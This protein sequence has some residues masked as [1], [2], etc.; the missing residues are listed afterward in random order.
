[1]GYYVTAAELRAKAAAL[2]TM[3]G[4]FRAR[5]V[6][7]GDDIAAADTCVATVSEHWV[8]P[9]A[10]SDLACVSAY[11][12]E[13]RG[14]PYALGAV[15]AKLQAFADRAEE[16]GGFLAGC[17]STLAAEQAAAPPGEPL[18]PEAWS[19]QRR[20][21]SL[22]GD[23]NLACITHAAAITV[24]SELLEQAHSAYVTGF[25]A[26]VLAGSAYAVALVN[27]AA[28]AGVDLEALGYSVDEVRA[29]L[30]A[31][32]GDAPA[33]ELVVVVMSALTA[34]EAAAYWNTL[35]DEERLAVVQKRPDLAAKALDGGGT[36]TEIELG[37]L[38]E[39][40]AYP[41]FS[42]AFAVAFE[43]SVGLR[44]VSIEVGGGYTV[45]AMKMSDGTVQVAVVKD[46][47]AG[48]G[49]EAQ[50]EGGEGE[51]TVG[52]V[53]S[54]ERVFV[55]PDEATAEQ[56]ITDLQDAVR[57]YS[58][59]EAV[60][61]VVGGLWFLV[62]RQ[63]APHLLI[64]PNEFDRVIGDL[65]GDY[66]A[67]RTSG[68]GVYANVQVEV[69]NTVAEADIEGQVSVG[70]Y[71]TDTTALATDVARSGIIVS[72]TLGVHAESASGGGPSGGGGGVFTVDAY[73]DE[74]GDEFMTVTVQGS[75][76][77]G[78]VVE[79]LDYAGGRVGAEWDGQIEQ[80]GVATVEVTIPIDG[81]TAENVSGVVTSLATGTLPGI[82]A[83]MYDDAEITVTVDAT[84]MDV[85]S[86][87]EFDVATVE[88]N[89]DHDVTRSQNIVTLHKFPGGEIY[90]QNDLDGMIADELEVG[91]DSEPDASDA[92][93]A[94]EVASIVPYHPDAVLYDDNGQPVAVD[95][96]TRFVPLEGAGATGPGAGEVEA[97]L[98]E[99]LDLSD[100]TS[101]SA[102]AAP[103]LPDEDEVRSVYG[104]D[105]FIV[106]DVFGN[107]V[108]VYTGS[109]YS[110][111]G[112][113]SHQ[114]FYDVNGV[115]VAV[116]YG[117]TVVGLEDLSD[118]ADEGAA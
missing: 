62:N 118:T 5:T 109:E 26:P 37:S 2:G 117:E 10:V 19:A 61:D 11:L 104:P 71:D 41:Q 88:A 80:G 85:N 75:L 100:P 23:W 20:I 13:I 12:E 51:A 46:F 78:T 101:G 72:G 34:A 93:A 79:A 29:G 47:H 55:F 57:G 113:N 69:E 90:S 24:A 42:E 40:N 107:P 43:L 98:T 6:F 103:N 82:L 48:A 97:S 91:P 81:A 108:A 63:P 49:A 99:Q 36:L 59:S 18:S 65:W 64:P 76:S 110:R 27:L 7:F 73:T 52:V 53:M 112:P 60:S 1:M 66:G 102:G 56:A 3:A 74:N 114:L 25:S 21:E 15:A 39:A 70:V 89:V 67:V 116:D 58:P 22:A 50:T 95:T 17:E 92:A 30:E 28:A 54:A 84:T 94:G 45:V 8:G 32:F 14:M 106:H 9:R 83:E 111:F 87:I 38:D 96:G 105:A 16:L 77:T 68:G 33:G 86:E 115:P 31:G 44:V 4:Q 35:S